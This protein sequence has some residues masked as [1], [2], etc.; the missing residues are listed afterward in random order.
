MVTKFLIVCAVAAGVI[1]C[2]AAGFCADKAPLETVPKVELDKY[3][4]LWYEIGRFPTWF[5]KA[6]SSATAE[7]SLNKNGAIKVLNTSYFAN[8]KTESAKGKAWVVDKNTNA[9]LKV[10]FFWPFAGDYWVI[11]LGKNYEYA[12]VGHPGRNYLWILSRTPAMD[13]TVYNKTIEKLKEQGYDTNKIF[14]DPPIKK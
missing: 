2:A 14:R 11:Q 8:G 1:L 4:G 12:V 13:D 6:G 10:S 3:L 7:Y 9:K 5:Q